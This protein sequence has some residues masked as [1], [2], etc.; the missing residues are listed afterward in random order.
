MHDTKL[1]ALVYDTLYRRYYVVNTECSYMY[2]FDRKVSSTQ[3]AIAGEYSCV[4]D[5]YMLPL[6]FME[7]IEWNPD[8]G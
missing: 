4:N 8:C 7:V 3:V 2:M 5:R 6:E 1:R